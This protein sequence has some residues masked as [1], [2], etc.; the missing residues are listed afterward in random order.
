MNLNEFPELRGKHSIFSP[1]NP[2]F[3][4]YSPDEF[5]SK[6]IGRYRQA[7]GTDIHEYAFLCIKRCHK[8]TS[9]RELNKDLDCFIFDKYYDSYKDAIP[10]ECEREL[11]CLNYVSSVCPEVLESVKAYINDAIGFKMYPEVVLYYTDDFRGT[12]DSLIFSNNILRIHDLKTGSGIAHMEQLIGYAAL[13]CLRHH[14]HP[15]KFNTELRI[16][17]NGEI[18]IATPDGAEIQDY[19]ERYRNFANAIRIN[20]GGS[21]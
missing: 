8:V 13:F 16:Y 1:S 19:V 9:V 21:V 15:D 6:L 20:E 17:Q 18:N 2:S 3:F 7:L 12:A 4:N 11:A 10:K 5:Y 14:K